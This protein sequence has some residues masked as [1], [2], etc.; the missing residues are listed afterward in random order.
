METTDQETL[1]EE[2]LT[3]HTIDVGDREMGCT[4][5]ATD[6]PRPSILMLHEIF[7]V[8]F[9]MREVMVRLANHGYTVAAPDLFHRQEPGVELGYEEDDRPHAMDLLEGTDVEQAIE[10]VGEAVQWLQDQPSCN[11]K[12]ALLGFC[13]GGRLVVLA[14]NKP[15]VDAVA[16]FYPAGLENHQDVLPTGGPPMLIEFGDEDGHIPP[17]VADLIR[18]ELGGPGNEINIFDGAGHAFYNPHHHGYSETH[19]EVAHDHLIDFLERT[20]G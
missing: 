14:A 13:L 15:G 2:D 12:I 9:A 18:E 8:N 16:A 17:D 5:A 7:G 11:G 1:T 6:E 3:H 10:D 4:L 20:I 19:A